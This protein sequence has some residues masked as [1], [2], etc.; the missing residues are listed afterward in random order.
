MTSTMGRATGKGHGQG[1]EDDCDRYRL[2]P[3]HCYA[4]LAS[5]QG[6]SLPVTSTYIRI[7]IIR[8]YYHGFYNKSVKYAFCGS[9]QGNTAISIR[10]HNQK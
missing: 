7:A 10:L 4:L 6:F 2:L 5:T 8:F 1:N 9:R 3:L